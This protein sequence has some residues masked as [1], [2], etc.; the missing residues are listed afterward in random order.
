MNKEQTWKAQTLIQQIIIEDI[1]KVE[2]INTCYFILVQGR[3]VEDAFM[4]RA[5]YLDENNIDQFFNELNTS[6]TNEE[7]ASGWSG[8]AE[9]I[10]RWIAKEFVERWKKED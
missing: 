5:H 6:I 7:K 9:S 1:K 2:D 8:M 10:M 3:N 4:R